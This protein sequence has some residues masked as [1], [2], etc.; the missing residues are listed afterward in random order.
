MTPDQLLESSFALVA[1]LGIPLAVTAWLTVFGGA[2]AMGAILR[3][4][5]TRGVWPTAIAVGVTGLAAHLL[6]YFVTLRITPDLAMEANP[7]WRVVIDNF[8]LSIAR[9]YG[10]TGKL[11]LSVL[12]AQLFAWHLS[13]RAS[14]FPAQASGV[15]DFIKQLGR[16]AP[17]M[18]NIRSFFAFAFALFGPYFFY[19][20]FMNVTGEASF[21]L[22][23]KLPSPPVAI[24]GYFVLVTFAYFATMWRA[25]SS[26]TAQPVPA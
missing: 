18:G 24:L 16:G 5:N 22:Y 8:G 11:L 26:R 25:F 12:S 2:L 13:H 21:D 23:E 17:R 14:L 7:I 15:L 3:T 20:T 9:V 1:R 4:C 19:I 6:D 10:L